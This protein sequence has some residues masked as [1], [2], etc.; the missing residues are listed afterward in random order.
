MGSVD[1]IRAD[2]KRI[3]K[4]TASRTS[5]TQNL[6]AF[7]KRLEHSPDM[8]FVG[9]NDARLPIAGLGMEHGK[10]IILRSLGAYLKPMQDLFSLESGTIA[11]AV[12]DKGV[13]DIAI[14]G[15]TDCNAMMCCLTDKGQP[16]VL[17]YLSGL[18]KER[19]RV[20]DM[21]LPP[22]QAARLMEQAAVCAT[23][24]N[25]ERTYPAIQEAV[26]AGKIRFHGWV[27]DIH[28]ALA[29]PPEPFLYELTD[30]KNKTFTL[31]ADIPSHVA[32]ASRPPAS[33]ELH[34]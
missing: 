34:P 16:E 6:E 31:M 2:Q 3:K 24:D 13:T 26:A 19:Q 21:H 28:K 1:L 29:E 17:G 25:L 23:I 4:A 30:R 10:A 8:L 27:M 32:S 12:R 33:Q 9:C 14:M 22:D 11:F 7:F 18:K 15:H 5:G 20:L